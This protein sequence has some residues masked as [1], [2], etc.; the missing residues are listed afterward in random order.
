M[1]VCDGEWTKVARFGLLVG[2]LIFAEVGEALARQSATHP[3]L[4]SASVPVAQP[5]R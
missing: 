2:P 4:L 1:S 3:V 5:P